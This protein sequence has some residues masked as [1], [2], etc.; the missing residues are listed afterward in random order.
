MP[1]PGSGTNRV[2]IGAIIFGLWLVALGTSLVLPFFAIYLKETIGLTTFQV[3]LAMSVKLW[4]GY[5]LTVVGGALTDRYGPRIVMVAGLA[6]RAAAYIGIASAH[7]AVPV[8]AWSALIGVGGALYLPAG[9]SAIAAMVAESDRVK[10]FSLRNTAHNLG[11][12]L[13]PILG[14][15]ALVGNPQALFYMASLA[16]SLYALI[17]IVFVN[18]ATLHQ[19]HALKLNWRLGT[20]LAFD[21]RMLYLEAITAFYM[22]MYMQME[23]AMPLFAKDQFGEFA[24]SLLFTINAIT[25]VVAQVALS[26]FM[27]KRYSTSVTVAVALSCQAIGVLLVGL[28][29]GL[30]M[31]LVSVVIFTVGE[32][33]VD[34]RVDATVSDVVPPGLVGTALGLIG[35]AGALGGSLGNLAGGPAYTRAAEMG[36][37]TAFW[38]WL[39]F[40]GIVGALVVLLIGLAVEVPAEE[41]AS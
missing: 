3:G 19:E 34:P 33:L 31:F 22:F 41:E 5:G 27:A 40:A 30:V 20:I 23:L 14:M 1:Q 37:P 6:I 9:K 12:A 25:V 21:W 38:S 10:L 11:V 24:V 32:I 7:S 17:T 26:S 28:S 15:A 13:G 39:G 18:A 8:I 16:Y 29:H 4:A 35:A 2:S 36:N